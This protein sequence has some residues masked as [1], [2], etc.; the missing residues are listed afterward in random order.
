[1]ISSQSILHPHK[2]LQVLH[3]DTGRTLQ[4]PFITNFFHLIT[5]NLS[6]VFSVRLLVTITGIFDAS[7]VRRGSCGVT[8]IVG[9]RV[10]RARFIVQ[11]FITVNI[12]SV[13]VRLVVFQRQRYRLV[14]AEVLRFIADVL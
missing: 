1:M 4:V 14:W 11:F 6:V 9:V 5:T 12:C 8:V 3:V 2:L 13:Q 10:G 7:G